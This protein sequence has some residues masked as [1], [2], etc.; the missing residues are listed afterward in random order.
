V[1]ARAMLRA[2]FARAVFENQKHGPHAFVYAG[3]AGAGDCAGRNE[4]VGCA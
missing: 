1:F 2:V 4:T 3:L